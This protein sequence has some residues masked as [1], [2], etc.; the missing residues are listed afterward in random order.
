MNT[1]L[2]GKDG[3]YDEESDT[4]YGSCD[5]TKYDSVFLGIGQNFYEVPPS[6]YV[7]FD[8]ESD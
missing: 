8:E 2:K 5:L 4:Y 1:L 7:Y 3:L 6:K